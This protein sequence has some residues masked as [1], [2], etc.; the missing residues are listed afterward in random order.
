[1][2]APLMSLVP[3]TRVMLPGDIASSPVPQPDVLDQIYLIIK[4]INYSVSEHSHLGSCQVKKN[5]KIR[6]K[7]VLSRHHPRP[8]YPFSFLETCTTIKTTHKKTIFKKK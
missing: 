7:L 2:N 4:N 8:A 6:E 5:I 1:M 3:V